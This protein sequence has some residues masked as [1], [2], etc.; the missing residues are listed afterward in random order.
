MGVHDDC[1]PQWMADG[2]TAIISH[3]SKEEVFQ[4][5]KQEDKTN[6]GEAACVTDGFA[7]SLDVHQHLGNG[8]GAEADVSEGQVGEEEV[9]GRVEVG[10]RADSQD[11]EQVSKHSQK[12]NDEKK[13]K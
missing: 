13:N 3:C 5:C 4:A 1:V 7:L 6:L 8:G 10:V 11:D 12:I 9:H 2:H